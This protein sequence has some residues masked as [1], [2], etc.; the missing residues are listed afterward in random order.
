MINRQLAKNSRQA[1][2]KGFTLVE[3]IASLVII[4][5]LVGVAGLGIVQ[6]AKGFMITRAGSQLAIDSDF[7]LTRIRKSVRSLM[8]VSEAT[9]SRLTLTRLDSRLGT[10]TETFEYKNGALFLD[11]GTGTGGPAPLMKNISSFEFH[12]LDE[13][14]NEWKIGT[15]P[16]GELAIVEARLKMRG[17]ENVSLDFSERILP[18]NTFTPSRAYTPPGTGTTAAQGLC[19]LETLYPGEPGLIA[20]ARD[21]RE[22]RLKKIPGGNTLQ[23]LYYQIGRPL[24]DTARSNLWLA[25]IMRWMSAPLVALLFFVEFFPSGLA[26]LAMAAWLMFRLFTGIQHHI[27]PGRKQ[28]LLKERQTAGSVLLSLIVTMTI[29][30]A[31]GAG[32]ISM[33]N[34]SR[35]SGASSILGEQ[36]YYLAESGL[37]YALDRFMANRDDDTAFIDS[38]SSTEPDGSFPVS[39]GNAF[40]LDARC[41]YFDPAEGDP[42][43]LL[44]AFGNGLPDKIASAT[45]PGGG[46]A[47][48]LELFDTGINARTIV[49]A[50]ISG[51]DAGA[52]TISYS[53]TAGL[54]GGV[55]SDEYV[56]PVA[57]TTTNQI[58]VKASDFGKP[59]GSS[60][61]II[62][63]MSVFFPTT[64]GLVSFM[65][66]ADHDG[67][68]DDKIFLVYD[69]LDG[70]RLT[71]L[72]NVPGKEPLPVNGVDIA[73][74]TPVVLGRYATIQSTGIVGK[75]TSQETSVKLTLNQ[76]LD[77]AQ[78]MK[79][80]AN[81]TP[82][83]QSATSVIGTAT[84]QPDNSLKIETTES[85][86]AFIQANN[87]VFQQESV[88]AQDWAC[89]DMPGQSDFLKNLWLRSN[90]RLSYETQV[91]VKFTETEDDTTPPF[92]NHPGCYMPGII[93]RV[94]NAGTDVGQATYYGISF[95]RG[96]QGTTTHTSG[97]G[98]GG[99]TTW[100]SEDDDIADNL[101]ADHGSNSSFT[102]SSSCENSGFEPTNWDD[103]PPLDGIPY[104]IFW[105]KNVSTDAAGNPV[106]TGCGGASYSPF[107]WLAYMPLV[108][109]EKA[110]IYYYENSGVTVYGDTNYN[111]RQA[112]F[113]PGD[114]T[115]SECQALGMKNDDVESVRVG[116]GYS[117]T[118]YVDDNFGGQ[119][120]TL[121]SSDPNLRNNYYGFFQ[122]WADKTSS[123]RVTGPAPVASG[124]YDGPVAGRTPDATYTAWKLTD[125]YGLFKRYTVDGVE[126]LGMPGD[127]T[128]M[129]P[130]TAF[131]SDGPKPVANTAYIV[132][133][134]NVSDADQANKR[135]MNYRLY[136][137]EWTTI[138]LQIFE[139]EGDLDCNPDTGTNGIERINAVSAFFGSNEAAGD[140]NRAENSIKDGNRFPYPVSTA[141]NYLSY[142]VKWLD[143][144]AYF[145]EAVWNGLGIVNTDEP[146]FP[147]DGGYTSKLVPNP[148]T[149]GG[150]GGFSD[151]K[152]VEKGH[153][154]EGDNTIVY[155]AT[156][157]TRNL[158]T[159]DEYNFDTEYIPE[160]GLH[161]LG[162]SAD[163]EA[164]P[165]NRETAYFKDWYWRFFEG[166]STGMVPGV[167]SE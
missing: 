37:R 129:D 111:D 15:N 90:K 147:T 94:R 157:L 91:K 88:T 99:Q 89:S 34:T 31:I 138:G 77:T 35:Y 128:I 162:V 66:D 2:E 153:D 120:L 126:V 56:L 72:R 78:I 38:L 25:I 71:G 113:Q 40:S 166:G 148:Y 29:L 28:F 42:S 54:S 114:Y 53:I 135:D 107:E 98:C 125:P 46:L 83:E 116:P 3:I 14:N 141:E 167:I 47:G 109:V 70:N 143:D 16:I 50:T 150:C 115:L 142:P 7:V 124:W 59:A 63:N 79:M 20:I 8:Q 65:A 82:G 96:I 123:L 133:P 131:D 130:A 52:G 32:A 13:Q 81:K 92:A 136:L 41:F 44:G 137:K 39:Q 33:L 1:N 164:D 160:I 57:L 158:S 105:Q 86:Y 26:A 80:I 155:S 12:Y 18:R 100:R 76:P 36:A 110:V 51:I 24:A 119:S 95:M 27:P 67:S 159:G 127:I 134:G 144:N 75:G 84:I 152:L 4:S 132:F 6:V 103:D 9:Q 104:L 64:R 62:D 112:D 146:S 23:A 97:S 49:D 48:H 106:S 118:L 74:N 30:A 5:L 156:F 43:T 22:N 154:T 93:F 58:N 165:D 139:M 108:S 122:N 117:V 55:K 68:Y 140:Q 145:T 151:I 69:R 102:Y 87:N 19:L 21:F 101:F 73:A 163:P 10:I 60:S 149:T 161:T 121:N 17:P 45:I 61:I 11:D 85:T